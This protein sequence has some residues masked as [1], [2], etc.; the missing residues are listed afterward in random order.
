MRATQLT[1]QNTMGISAAQVALGDGLVLAGGD[2]ESGKTSFLTAIQLALFG[3]AVFPNGDPVKAGTDRATAEVVLGDGTETAYV[4]TRTIR[5]TDKGLAWTLKVA[6]AD[7][8]VYGSP[9]ALLDG[10]TR[11][12]GLDPLAFARMKPKEQVEA[13]QGLMHLDFA[14]IDARIKDAYE[15]RAVVNRDVAQQA[16][17]LKTLPRHADAPAALV[18][19]SDLAQEIGAGE[20]HNRGIEAMRQT[21][22]ETRIAMQDL[23]GDLHKAGQQADERAADIERQIDMLTQQIDALKVQQANILGQ[24]DKARD[25]IAQRIAVTQ[26]DERKLMERLDKAEPADVEALRRRLVGAEQVN[27]QVHENQAHT[28]AA[29][30]LAAMQVVSYDFTQALDELR[31][32]KERTM[33]AA[34]WPLEGLGFD[35]EGAG[36]TWNGLPLANAPGSEQIRISLRI[37]MAASPGL[38]TIFAD[39]GEM[40]DAAHRRVIAEMAEAEGYQILMTKVGADADCALVIEGGVIRKAEVAAP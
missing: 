17:V 1:L 34:P 12:R 28:K 38:R 10:L 33:E 31:R 35:S 22:R 8:A 13:L 5:R 23:D 36:V 2:N 3:K 24:C 16:A 9:Q 6:N 27:Q 37:A 4:V 21:L 20:R 25:D 19:L 39:N 26:A 11:G 14:E 32:Q 7:G 30:R 18:D 15:K 40:L 29:E